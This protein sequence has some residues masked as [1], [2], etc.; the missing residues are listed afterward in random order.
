M[1]KISIE[2]FKEAWFSFE[3][4]EKIKNWILDIEEWRIYDEDEVF[5]RL[6]QKVSSKFLVNV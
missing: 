4:I 6:H 1:S 3:E 2:K 5:S